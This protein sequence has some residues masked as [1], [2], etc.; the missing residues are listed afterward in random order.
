MRVANLLLL[1]AERRG[2][3]DASHTQLVTNMPRHP[4]PSNAPLR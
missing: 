3:P 4:Q 1:R 2:G